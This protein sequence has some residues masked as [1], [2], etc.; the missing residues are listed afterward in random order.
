MQVTPVK[1]QSQVNLSLTLLPPYVTSLI[2][3]DSGTFNLL[4]KVNGWQNMIFHK[5]SLKHIPGQSLNII[6]FS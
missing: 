1:N 3:D 2:L 6:A 5:R 4:D